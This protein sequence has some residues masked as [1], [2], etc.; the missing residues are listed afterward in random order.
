MNLQLQAF[1]QPGFGIEPKIVGNDLAL[2]LTGTGDMAAVL[3]LRNCLADVH[4]EMVRLGL[5]R[6]DI[7]VRALYLLN[8]SCLKALVTLI[9]EA[10][11]AKASYG[12]RFVVDP[13]L[14]WQRR[15]LVA[16]Q[17]MAPELV[18]IEEG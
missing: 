12:I 6:V 15:A 14:S 9:Y 1:A 3:P 11:K 8:S 4:P 7:D 18:T 17:R 5:Q 16:L 2:V 10:Q 13:R